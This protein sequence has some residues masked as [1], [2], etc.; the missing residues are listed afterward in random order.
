MDIG[1]KTGGSLQSVTSV[2][3]VATIQKPDTA[4]PESPSAPEIGLGAAGISEN[5]GHVSVAHPISYDAFFIDQKDDFEELIR[6]LKASQPEALLS[7]IHSPEDFD[8]D[9]LVSQ[10]R[11]LPSGKISLH[12]GRLMDSDRISPVILVIDFRQFSPSRLGEINELFD[13]PPR[14]QG[15]ALSGPVKIISLINESMLPDEK[16]TPDK[17][18]GDFWRRIQQPD[19]QW[20]V[21]KAITARGETL[22]DYLSRRVPPLTAHSSNDST[23][24]INLKDK[25]W[26]TELFGSPDIDEHGNTFFRQGKLAN[27]EHVQHVVFKGAPWEDSRFTHSLWSALT[28]CRFEANGQAVNI[29]GQL[30]FSREEFTKD[31]VKFLTESFFWEKKISGNDPIATINSDSFHAC[32][33]EAI[34][35]ENGKLHRFDALKQWVS[36]MNGLRVTSPLTSEQWIN[37][38][39]RLK[40]LNKQDFKLYVD[41]PELQPALLPCLKLSGKRVQQS[42]NITVIKHPAPP[43]FAHLLSEGECKNSYDFVVTPDTNLNKLAWHLSIDSLEQNTFCKEEKAFIHALWAGRPIRIQGLETNSELAG[44]LESLFM[45]PPSLCIQGQKEVFLSCK[46]RVLWDQTATSESPIWQA[47]INAGEQIPNPDFKQWASDNFGGNGETIHA[48][49]QNIIDRIE[50]LPEAQRKT[51]TPLMMSKELLTEIHQQFLLE[52]KEYPGVDSG[53]LIRKTFNTVLFKQYRA[54]PEIYSYLKIQLA[55][56]LPDDDLWVDQEAFIEWLGNTAPIN[57]ET[58]ACHYWQLLR[59]INPKISNPPLD[60]IDKDGLLKSDHLKKIMAMLIYFAPEERQAELKFSLGFSSDSLSEY[61]SEFS[62]FT[63]RSYQLEKRVSDFLHTLNPKCLQEQNLF[64]KARNIARGLCLQPKHKTPD[65]TA[66]TTEALKKQFASELNPDYLPDNM[67][68]IAESLL[69]S[70][71]PAVWQFWEERRIKRLAAKVRQHPVVFIQGETGAG[72]SYI[73]K[74]IACRLNPEQPATSLTISPLT[75]IDDLF[76]RNVL[77]P[78]PGSS[79]SHTVFQP[80]P[81]LKWA[82]QPA[83]S[84]TVL[85][86]DEANLARPELWNCLKGL[87]E[88]KSCLYFHGQ[89]IPLSP[90]HRIIMTGNPDH[91]GGRKNNLFLKKRIPQLYYRSFSSSFQANQVVRPELEKHFHHVC[92]PAQRQTL[93]DDTLKAAM[94]LYKAYHKLLPEHEFTPRDLTDFNARLARYLSCH[95]PDQMTQAGVNRL[96][97]LAMEN[98]LIGELN[99]VYSWRIPAMQAWYENHFPCNSRLLNTHLEK[100]DG[101]YNGW[102]ISEQR[103]PRHHLASQASTATKA[104]MRF[105]LSNQSVK[106]L[107]QNL[108]LDLEK[109]SDEKESGQPH[110]GRHATLIRGPAGRGKDVLI[111]RLVS[112]WNQSAE[113]PLNVSRINAGPQ[114]WDA[115]QKAIES[116]RTKGEILII[117]ELNMIKTEYLEG[118]LN[119]LLTGEAAPGFHLFVTINPTSYTGR[120]P[121]SKALQSRF[122]TLNIPE[123]TP[124]DLEQIASTLIE[125]KEQATLIAKW[126]CQLQAILTSRK[127]PIRPTAGDISKLAEKLNSISPPLSGKALQQLF[128]K[129]YVLYLKCARCSM[130]ELETASLTSPHGLV[131]ESPLMTELTTDLNQQY[132]CQLPEPV[133]ILKGIS[134]DY[135][136]REGTMVLDVSADQTDK[137]L[138]TQAVRLLAENAW[139]KKGL[140]IQSPD[141]HSILFRACY[142]RWQHTFAAENFQQYPN[143]AELFPMKEEEEGTLAI[144][145]NQLLIEE[146]NHLFKSSPDTQHLLS[147]R[148]TLYGLPAESKDPE[149][150]IT[151]KVEESSLA[152]RSRTEKPSLLPKTSPL[153]KID[154]NTIPSKQTRTL[155]EVFFN[156]DTRLY[157]KTVQTLN[158][159]PDGQMDIQ[160]AQW[161]RNGFEQL[162]PA[163]LGRTVVL[164]NNQDYGCIITKASNNWQL[165]PGLWPHARLLSAR[166]SPEVAIEWRRDTYTGQLIYRVPDG[167]GYPFRLEFVLEEQKVD[168]LSGLTGEPVGCPPVLR[169]AFDQM[170]LNH[171]GLLQQLQGKDLEETR[172]NLTQFCRAFN[173]NKPLTGDGDLNLLCRIIVEQQGSCRHRAWAFHALATYFGIHSHIINNTRH[174]WVE[175]STDS[176]RMWNACDLGGTFHPE[177]INKILP[178]DFSPTAKGVKIN[179]QLLGHFKDKSKEELDSLAKSMGISAE[180]LITAIQAPEG[181]PLA[182]GDQLDSH[183]MIK[184]LLENSEDSGAFLAGVAM[185]LEEENFD[186]SRYTNIIHYYLN[187]H[188]ELEGTLNPAVLC[189]LLLDAESKVEPQKVDVWTRKM[190]GLADLLVQSHKENP[191]PVQRKMFEELLSFICL[192]QDWP[193]H[194][195]KACINALKILTDSDKYGEQAKK[196]LQ[197]VYQTLSQPLAIPP[198][199]E[200]SATSVTGFINKGQSRMLE[201]KLSGSDIKTRYSWDT[202][203]ALSPERW[204]KRLPPFGRSHVDRNLQP[205]VMMMAPKKIR[206][207][208]WLH[209]CVM[210]KETGEIINIDRG[211]LL[212]NRI[213]SVLK[214]PPFNCSDEKIETYISVLVERLNKK[215]YMSRKLQ[216]DMTKDGCTEEQI[217]VFTDIVYW[218]NTWD[219]LLT[220]ACMPEGYCRLEEVIYTKFLEYL[221]KTTQ[222][223][224]GKLKI[225]NAATT[226]EKPG[227]A[228][229][230]T[231]EALKAFIAAH[232]K[233][234]KWKVNP[235]LLKS[236]LFSESAAVI[237]KRDFNLFL[238]EY[239]TSLEIPFEPGESY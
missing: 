86:L 178:A 62:R 169:T 10:V 152:S 87:F 224:E 108:W 4:V 69:Q 63:L 119:D 150:S 213:R 147:L 96:V 238:N 75:T 155:K 67:T 61:E 156:T 136:A 145:E 239:I 65:S 116:A 47:A 167:S 191:D 139:S 128:E 190:E 16:S 206:F 97:W 205:P 134:N 162:C 200:K 228:Q 117:S 6:D 59:H 174:A 204:V 29:P 218:P 103:L 214:A 85:I 138:M 226:Y 41:E 126:H 89:R 99:S 110:I 8:N 58:I 196:R 68:D 95:S 219:K 232:L 114:N 176:G 123:Y 143:F 220:E 133:S 107:L 2:E 20:Q 42:D 142:K 208:A 18:M 36:G 197:T 64:Q 236:S 100:F 33:Q 131:N 194:S 14:I 46:V 171:P 221:C 140:P 151:S 118:A 94:A 149:D 211:V 153:K 11:V 37:L 146:L 230:S 233:E 13:T 15:K 166:T 93:I 81:L 185:H 124:A 158:Y 26:R 113:T 183:K 121:I 49:L 125:N 88:P 209:Y 159:R 180:Q 3:S 237:Q 82:E 203:G 198:H 165:L 217:K 9:E 201:N 22:T 188:L 98:T 24:V 73:A 122:R 32:M 79:D 210:N 168:K 193:R 76:G 175:V 70:D 54:K 207:P 7:V 225:Y 31:D 229:P 181:T 72:K 141:D 66:E 154:G 56:V 231:P 84:P 43:V 19:N 80:G 132:A 92:D 77:T 135:N 21:D 12:S 35:A 164:A 30:L 195:N 235:D 104:P 179:Q 215:Y 44:Q 1:F 71:N 83:K 40:Q 28:A 160:D 170:F 186:V 161:G 212:Q 105:D 227:W 182:L 144:P 38:L 25:N 223:D 216:E 53:Q 148:N 23:L 187:Q 189:Q 172:E 157:R 192:K 48:V 50:S 27:L 111:D 127:L 17:P 5:Q 177:T 101:F 115:V 222:A 234:E 39:T 91:F 109:V 34:I 106:S 78:I 51:V 137:E 184:D 129:H 102:L 60:F 130:A 55:R 57:K 173:G 45:T 112:H 120:H 202:E 52:L 163:L 74:K 90:N 199:P